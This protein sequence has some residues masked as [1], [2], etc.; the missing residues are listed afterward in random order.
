M[1]ADDASR[2]AVA[3]KRD[4][5]RQCDRRRRRA[6]AGR[7][8]SSSVPNGWLNEGAAK[9]CVEVEL[10]LRSTAPRAEPR[11]TRK[12]A[13]RGSRE[14]QRRRGRRDE[15]RRRAAAPARRSRASSADLRRSHLTASS[16]HEP[17]AAGRSLRRGGRST[18]LDEDERRDRD[19]D[20]RLKHGVVALED[21]VDHQRAEPRPRE[22]VLDDH[23]AAEQRADDH[24][25]R[26][27]RR[28]I[29]AFGSRCPSTTWRR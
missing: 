15:P 3:R 14:R 28:R 25:E 22:D 23:R 11:P 19:Q 12:R 27:Q 4:L 20:E 5:E 21:R 13:P 10:V 17:A 26:R 9:R 16:A 8:P 24:A 7:G 29:A 2:H 1:R 18:R 6:S